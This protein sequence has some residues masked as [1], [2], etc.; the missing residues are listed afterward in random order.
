MSREGEAEGGKGKSCR[1]ISAY[2]LCD[3][4]I[5]GVLWEARFGTA[6][7]NLAAS[8]GPRRQDGRRVAVGS[9]Y[10]EPDG[11]LS[12]WIHADSMLSTYGRYAHSGSGARCASV[13]EISPEVVF[14]IHGF[15]SLNLIDSLLRNQKPNR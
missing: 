8:P 9:I 5:V 6:G 10:Q 1:R 15:T 4:L 13:L 11:L 12:E 14:E 3:S 7:S 2:C